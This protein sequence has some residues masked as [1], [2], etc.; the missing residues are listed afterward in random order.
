MEKIVSA[1]SA[2]KTIAEFITAI[3]TA[4]IVLQNAAKYLPES[5]KTFFT[6]TLPAFFLGY[7]CL[8]KKKVHFFKAVKAQKE[9]EERQ[10]RLLSEA[11]KNAGLT[12]K[13]SLILNSDEL[14][15]F[16]IDSKVISTVTIR[17]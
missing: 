6:K 2:L 9:Y 10:K 17:K 3:C 7:K 13:D 1:F 11:I 14:L 12:G 5:A 16:L 8:D 15:K 4:V